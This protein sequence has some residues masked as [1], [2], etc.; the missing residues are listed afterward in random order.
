MALLN[1][2]KKKK[3]KEKVAPVKIAEI[4]KKE[5]K[6]KTEVKPTEARVPRERKIDL[7]WQILKTPH[8]T[9]KATRLS[10]GNQYVFNVYF[11]T[12]K[13]EIKKAIEDI[14]GVNVISVKII[15]IPKKRRRLGRIQGWKAGYK[16]AIVRIRK[17]EKIEV[18]PR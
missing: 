1:I 12:N 11:R 7:A 5:A 14:F 17:G 16:K 9:E 6:K 3:I 13:T 10:E 4:K 18:M 8:V 15:N 2:F